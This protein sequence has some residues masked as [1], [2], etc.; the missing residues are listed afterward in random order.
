MSTSEKIN[1]TI[2]MKKENGEPISNSNPE[3]LKALSRF[4]KIYHLTELQLT[5]NED[6][7]ISLNEDVFSSVTDFKQRMKFENKKYKE[8]KIFRKTFFEITND[9]ETL[10]LDIL[11]AK[12]LKIKRMINGKN[13]NE[14][15][16]TFLS[17]TIG[18][19]ELSTK[20]GIESYLTLNEELDACHCC[21]I[22][23][24]TYEIIHLSAFESNKN[25]NQLI[26]DSTDI[27]QVCD[28]C[29]VKLL[30]K[31][32]NKNFN[33][34][35]KEIGLSIAFKIDEA[36][37]EDK[38]TSKIDLTYKDEVFGKYIS[39]GDP[40][41]QSSFKVLNKDILTKAL[42]ELSNSGM[43]SIENVKID[44]NNFFHDEEQAYKVVNDSIAYV[45]SETAAYFWSDII[46][47]LKEK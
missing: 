1:Y 25:L 23:D 5:L 28:S 34:K 31:F 43:K 22:I 7:S 45:D 40:M 29:H 32:S 24:T 14:I 13:L 35:D 42:I 21:K 20:R 46:S 11:N 27:E 18:N 38:E 4:S 8:R 26:M 9:P 36:F 37:N 19:K 15:A 44:G 17:E 39:T 10:F 2:T 12:G 6:K 3:L 47:I 30:E 16:I 33:N 41:M